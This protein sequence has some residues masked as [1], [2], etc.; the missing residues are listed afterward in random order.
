MKILNRINKLRIIKKIFGTF[1]RLSIL[2]WILLLV[3][4]IYTNPSPLKNSSFSAEPKRNNSEQTGLFQESSNKEVSKHKI[5]RNIATVEEKYKALASV[6]YS[7]TIEPHLTIIDRILAEKG[8]DN[9]LLFIQAMFYIGQHESHWR[10]YAVSS[11]NIKGGHPTGIFQFLPGTFKSV[12]GGDI[13]NSEDQ[14]RAFI[15][16]AER[17]RTDEFQTVFICSFNPC[18]SLEAK[19]HILNFRR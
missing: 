11:F 8:L 10:P 17:G 5:T 15:T 14:I 9:D 18:L 16:M 2:S 7:H 13:F 1:I 19:L 12:S 4:H 6:H 3:V